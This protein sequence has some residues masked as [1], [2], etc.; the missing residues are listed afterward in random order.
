MAAGPATI[1]PGDRRPLVPVAEALA[2]VLEG[3]AALATERVPLLETAGRILAEDVL[4]RRTQPPFAASAMDGYA[5]RAADLVGAPV[6]LR[7]IGRA[8]AGARFAGTLG[9]GEAVRIF[10]GAPLPEGADT[11]LIQENA[12]AEGDV[13]HALQGEPEGRFVRRRGLD[14]EEGAALLSA[15]MRIGARHIAL[16]AAMNHAHLPVRRRPR[17]AI[18][19]TGDELVAPGGTPGPDQ[20]V[21]SN[22]YGLAALVTRW[23]G[24]PLDLGIVPDDPAATDAAIGRAAAADAD[25][26]VTLGGASVGEHDLIRGALERAG[27]RLAFWRVAMRPGK[28]LLSG[29]LGRMHVLGLP[30]NPVSSLVCALVFVRPLLMSLLGRPAGAGGEYMAVSS[31]VLAANDERQDYLRAS[32][33]R[34]PEGGALIATPFEVQDSS[35]LALLARADGLLVRPPF[36][37]AA[38]AGEPCRVLVIE[39]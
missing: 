16:A 39:D 37:A 10:T 32:L 9:A 33:H 18:L 3:A 35:M 28:P 19:A 30:G 1:V 6:P 4:A 34:D 36:A 38:A 5:V 24:E 22:S 13:I 15:G 23:G 17:V 2:A 21:A 25:V 11:I 31:R 20:I 8:Q 26:L 12:R 29:R 27:L 14:F 7:L